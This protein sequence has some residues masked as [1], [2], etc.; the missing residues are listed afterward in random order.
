[1]KTAFMEIGFMNPAI[2]LTAV[3]FLNASFFMN[4]LTAKIAT[5]AIF[6]KTA[7]LVLIAFFV[8]TANHAKIV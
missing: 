6:P 3:L 7:Q 4:A 2:A 8:T 5:T 1:M